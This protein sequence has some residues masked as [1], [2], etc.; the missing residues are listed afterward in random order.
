MNKA[1]ALAALGLRPTLTR[2]KSFSSSRE[3]ELDARI[4]DWL[5]EQAPGFRLVDIKYSTCLVPAPRSAMFLSALVIYTI[6]EPIED[7]LKDDTEEVET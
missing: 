6:P 7:I 3:Y 1:E 4:N 2:V 5:E